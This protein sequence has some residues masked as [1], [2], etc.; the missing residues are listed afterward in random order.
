M[1]EKIEK[2]DNFSF[3][4]DERKERFWWERNED[5]NIKARS[6]PSLEECKKSA[7]LNGWSDKGKKIDK[8]RKKIYNLSLAITLEEKLFDKESRQGDVF[9]TFAKDN[10]LGNLFFVIDRALNILY[11]YC[12]TLS[13]RFR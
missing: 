11:N 9:E 4:M 5:N 3:W 13:F 1:D 6:Y 8:L 2:S 10:R 12:P 7:M